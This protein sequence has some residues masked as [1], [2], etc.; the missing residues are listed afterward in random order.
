MQKKE[1]RKDIQEKT[2]K[3]KE[4]KAKMNDGYEEK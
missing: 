4:N 2:R 3:K 1:R